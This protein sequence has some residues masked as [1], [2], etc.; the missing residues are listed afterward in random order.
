MGL[1]HRKQPEAA[2]PD[3]SLAD[4]EPVI[5]SSICTGEKV[6]CMRER[7]TGRLH[8][9]LFLRDDADLRAFCRHYGIRPEQVKTIY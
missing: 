8:E 3:Y 9:I 2:L 7:E 5:R 1:F 4:F 6:A